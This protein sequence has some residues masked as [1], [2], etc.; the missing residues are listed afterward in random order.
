[1]SGG[2]NYQMFGMGLNA[3][4][5]YA[6]NKANYKLELQNIEAKMDTMKLAFVERQGQL[7]FQ[8][9]EVLASQRANTARR[10][11]ATGGE[12]GEQAVL[13]KAERQESSDLVNM[14]NRERSLLFEKKV[15]KFN[16]NMTNTRIAT[17]MAASLMSYAAE[18]TKAASTGGAGAAGAGA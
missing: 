7:A 18:Q 4:M 13:R 6:A 14:L 10:G 5:Q 11:L 8:T 12:T 15:A 3:G 17:D 9:R 16:K 1:M 2:F